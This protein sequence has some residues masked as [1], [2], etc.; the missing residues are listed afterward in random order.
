MKMTKY[1]AF[2]KTPEVMHHII[3]MDRFVKLT[4]LEE[5]ML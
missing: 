5:D 2:G 3:K 4:Q 1:E